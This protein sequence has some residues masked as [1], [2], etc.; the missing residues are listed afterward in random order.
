LERENVPRAIKALR[1]ALDIYLLLDHRLDA[2]FCRFALGQLVMDAEAVPLYEKAIAQF[3]LS[4]FTFHRERCSLDLCIK[5]ARMGRYSDAIPVLEYLQHRIAY[6]G[7]PYVLRCQELLTECYCKLGEHRPA[8]KALQSI[9]DSNT[10]DSSDLKFQLGDS[11]YNSQ[12]FVTVLTN[13]EEKLEVDLLA[14][15]E[16]VIAAQ[17]DRLQ[18]EMEDTD[19]NEDKQDDSEDDN[20]NDED[21]NNHGD[22]NNDEDKDN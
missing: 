10:G 13:S 18:K 17:W 12:E 7:K 5:L 1:K 21:D 16:T 15:Y 11:K 6:V 8:I 2:A 19:G 22:D 4:A 9:L 20:L 3:N 14:A